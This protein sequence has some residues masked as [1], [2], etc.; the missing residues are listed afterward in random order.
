MPARLEIIQIAA[1]PGRTDLSKAQTQFNKWIRSIEKQRQLL[2]EW[3]TQSQVYRERHLAEYSPQ[4]QAYEA[5]RAELAYALD[6]AHG[7]TSLTGRERAKLSDLIINLVRGLL[8]DRD[9]R[10]LRE[11]FD[12][13]SPTD[14]A[15]ET[16][17]DLNMMRA[18]TE[19]VLN[20]EF[21][22]TDKFSS[23]EEM[24]LRARELQGRREAEEVEEASA[25]APKKSAKTLAKEQRLAAETQRLTQSLRDIYRKLA[26]ALHPDRE[27]DSTARERK[28]ALMQQVNQAYEKND[29]LRLLELQLEVEQ[30]DRVGLSA[31]PEERLKRY[32]K[33]LREQYSELTDEVEAA[34]DSFRA[35]FDIGLD[36]PLKPQSL[37]RVLQQQLADLRIATANLRHDMRSLQDMRYLKEWLKTYRVQ[38][39]LDDFTL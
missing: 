26:S 3:Q 18:H 25:A 27:Q 36:I 37:L 11:L 23:V 22:D 33:I 28:T 9:D 19:A 7:S 31:I 10:A 17:Q 14:F 38:E 5:L 1:Q 2:M 24:L 20:I 4:R 39:S 16:A 12:R 21:D 6:R 15:T 32:N 8:A 30:V 13:H 34:E 35:Q 29:L